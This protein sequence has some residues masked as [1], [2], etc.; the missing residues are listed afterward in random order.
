MK[1]RL[2][3]ALGGGE[4]VLDGR[5]FENSASIYARVKVGEGEDSF[6]IDLNRHLLTEIKDPLPEEPPVGAFVLVNTSVF[7]R[8]DTAGIDWWDYGQQTWRNWEEVCEFGTPVSLVPDPFAEPVELP[9]QGSDQDGGVMV[10]WYDDGVV[11][12]LSGRATA[13]F[14]LAVARDVARA[15]WTAPAGPAEAAS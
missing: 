2:P 6:T 11:L 10:D 15:F 4:C 14:P 13:W 1:Y 12:R 9:W 5:V 3:E 8:K 7:Q